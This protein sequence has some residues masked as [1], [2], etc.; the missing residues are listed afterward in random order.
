MQSLEGYFTNSGYPKQKVRN[1]L[2]TL[3][4]Q[5]KDSEGCSNATNWIVTFGP[6]F[7]EAKKVASSALEI[8]NNSYTWKNCANPPKVIVTA[9][10]SSNLKDLLFKR[11]A[12]SLGDSS[13]VT[14][15]C[16]SSDLKR[17]RGPTC[18]SCTLMSGKS[19]ITNS[20]NVVAAAGGNCLT[21]NLIYTA[22]CQL[23]HVNNTYVG[24]TVTDFR[25][26]IN[27]HH[28]SFYAI[29]KAKRNNK[30]NVVVDNTVWV[31][32]L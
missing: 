5:R 29:I 3:K 10:K 25:Q 2:R 20:G 7:E 22:E 6:G 21:K 11:K 28:S 32:P 27:G 19:S 14:G 26:R 9:R 12:I 15:P 4:Y 24:K 18:G 23:C 1:R 16:T 8:L 31:H 30:W 13:S 17:K